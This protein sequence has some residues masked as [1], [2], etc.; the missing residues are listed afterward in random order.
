MFC[1]SANVALDTLWNS[2]MYWCSSSECNICTFASCPLSCR[3][4]GNFSGVVLLEEMHSLWFGRDPFKLFLFKFI[5]EKEYFSLKCVTISNMTLRPSAARFLS[6]GRFQVAD[7]VMAEGRLENNRYRQECDVGSISL[8]PRDG[9]GPREMNE[10]SFNE[11]SFVGTLH[12]AEENFTS[13][14]SCALSNEERITS[15]PRCCLGWRQPPH[16]TT[17]T[18]RRRGAAVSS[19]SRIEAPARGISACG[20]HVVRASPHAA[21]APH[22]AAGRGSRSGRRRR[23][24][25]F[26][27]TGRPSSYGGGRAHRGGRALADARPVLEKAE[28]QPDPSTA[29]RRPALLRSLFLNGP[30]VGGSASR[31]SC[32]DGGGGSSSSTVDRSD[33]GIDAAAG[34]GGGGGGGSGDAGQGKRGAG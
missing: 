23:R 8:S 15:T 4:K 6:P 21:F 34:G 33:D 17:I 31:R 24:R 28:G 10:S 14:L 25:R 3:R 19:R 20:R 11:A 16:P 7:E 13:P 22:A 26:R 32:P 30:S 5:F 29:R 1:A 9:A 27:N 18:K 2:N 12:S